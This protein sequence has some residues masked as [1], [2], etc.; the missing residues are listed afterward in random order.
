VRQAVPRRPVMVLFNRKA[1]NKPLY[2]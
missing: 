2:Y 1:Y